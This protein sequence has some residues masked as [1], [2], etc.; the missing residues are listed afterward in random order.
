MDEEFDLDKNVIRVATLF[1]KTGLVSSSKEFK[2]M[3]AQKGLRINGELVEDT[4]MTMTAR[5]LLTP[6]K[7]SNGKKKHALVKFDT[8]PEN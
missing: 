1:A 7:L 3:V 5:E 2:R 6:V 8:T 4:A